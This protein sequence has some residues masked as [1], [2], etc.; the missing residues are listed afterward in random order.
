MPQNSLA[1]AKRR[2]SEA[3]ALL[4][5]RITQLAQSDPHGSLHDRLVVARECIRDAI[6][7]VEHAE[8]AIKGDSPRC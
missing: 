3:I 5:S 4:E 2:L 7:K 1:D 8:E 6:R